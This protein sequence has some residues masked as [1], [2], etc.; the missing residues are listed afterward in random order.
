MSEP[1]DSR[2]V[3]DSSKNTTLLT[4]IDRIRTAFPSTSS[5]D[6]NGLKEGFEERIKSYKAAAA[7][8]ATKC[9][10]SEYELTKEREAHLRTAR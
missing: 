9:S 3:V 5:R 2:C 1:Q 7:S 6:V 8:A 4:F 10:S